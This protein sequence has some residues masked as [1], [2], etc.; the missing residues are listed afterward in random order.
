MIFDLDP[1]VKNFAQVQE[2]AFYLK[3][4]LDELDLHNFVI[5]TGSRGLHIV[6]PIKQLRTF[7][8]VRSFAK[9][10]GELLVER[11]PKL[12]TMYY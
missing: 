2:S 1:S 3:D 9:S 7:N 6:T 8:W 5:T 12:F 10:I 11:H 4:L